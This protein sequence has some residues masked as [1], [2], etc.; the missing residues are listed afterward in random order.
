MPVSEAMAC[1]TPTVVGDHAAL[2]EVGRAGGSFLIE[3]PEDPNFVQ[4]MPQDNCVIR[5]RPDINSAVEI[6]DDLAKGRVDPTENIEKGL[7]FARSTDWKVISE[8]WGRLISKA[9]ESKR[10]SVCELVPGMGVDGLR[11]AEKKN[12]ELIPLPDRPGR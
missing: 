4:I 3:C 10:A 11:P 2:S 6:L 9:I 5:R 1:G 7:A 8:Q 12:G